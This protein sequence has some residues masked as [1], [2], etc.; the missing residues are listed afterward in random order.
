MQ[1]Q[2]KLEE[3]GLGGLI[4][5]GK[6]RSPTASGEVRALLLRKAS[7]G[8]RSG[9]SNRSRSQCRSAAAVSPRRSA[10]MRVM[11]AGRGSL[12][13]GRGASCAQRA[14]AWVGRVGQPCA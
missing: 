11:I 9:G 4:E 6:L 7:E 1:K 2:A 13:S 12:G 3:D 8:G 10:S 14:T 5:R